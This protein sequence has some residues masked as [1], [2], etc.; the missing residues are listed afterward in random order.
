M[1]IVL[2]NGNTVEATPDHIVYVETENQGKI[3]KGTQQWLKV[4]QLEQGM[5]MLQRTDTLVYNERPSQDRVSEAILV[6]WLQGDGFVGQYESGTNRSLTLEFMTA[7]DE[8]YEFLL[9]H[10]ERIFPGI[11]YKVRGVETV[12][13]DLAL[14]RIRLYG[15]GLRN[16]VERYDLEK[17]GLEMRIPR[18]VLLGGFEV[19]TA[20]L[21]ALFQ[22]DGSV[23][24]HSG[25]TDSFDVVLGSIS[26]DLVRDAQKLLANLGIYS[27]IGVCDDSREDRNTY[28]QLILG[29]KGERR[30][31]Q[32]AIGFVSGEKSEKLA[33]SIDSDV[34]GKNIPA[35][36]FETVARIEYVGEQPV[37]DIQTES[38]NYLSGNVVVH[39][40][41]IQSVTDDLVNDNGIMDLWVREA[42]LFKFGSGTGTNFSHL[43][44]EGEPLSGG[45]R[46]SGLMSFLKVGDRAAGVIKS[47][48]T[49]RRAAKMVCLD[50]DHP[51]IESFI[52]WKAREEQK[53]SALVAG[54]KIHHEKLKAVLDACY[55]ERGQL[56]TDPTANSKL[57]DALIAAHEAHIPDGYLV[58]TLQL[59]QSG[60][61][62]IDFPTF[63]VDWQSEAYQ[64]VSGQNA[65]NSVR[66]PNLFFEKLTRGDNWQLRWRTDGRVC[67]EIA[68]AEIWDKIGYAAWASADPGI[69]CDTTIN[70][71]HTCPKDG[72][73]NASNPCSEYMFLDDTACNLASLNLL[74]FFDETTGEFRIEAFQHACRLWTV[75][76]EISV[77]MAQYPSKTIARRS[78]DYR[79]LG[80]GYANLGAL[81]MSMGVPYGSQKALAVTGALTAIMTG[82][83]YATSAE[84]AKEHGP[85]ARFQDNREE[86]LRVMRNHR[87]AAYHARTDEYEGLSILPMPIDEKD[88]PAPL[89]KAARLAWD[90]AIKAGEK[91]GFRNAQTTVI[92]PTGT[93]GLLMDCDTTGI[94]PDFALVKFKKLAGGGYFRIINQSVPRALSKLGYSPQEV[95]DIIAYCTGHG[96]LRQAPHI[97]NH[98]LKQLGFTDEVLKRLE[99]ELP[100]AFDLTFV[101]NPWTLGRDFC[102]SV[103]ELTNEEMADT[104]LNLLEKLGFSPEQ[105]E[106]AN[107]HICG[108]MT[109]EGAP[110]LKPEHYPVFD[111][112]GKCGRIGKRFLDYRTH[113]DMMAAAQPFISGAISK[114][115]NM[116]AEASIPEVQEAFS[117][118]W[119]KMVKAIAIY[120]DGSK[121]SQPLNA[122]VAQSIFAAM[123]K[124]RAGNMPAPSP[125]A[126]VRVVASELAHQAVRKEL[127]KRRFGYTVKAT[128]AGQRVYLRTGEYEDG[129]L[130]EIFIDVYKEGAAYRSLMN[131]FAIAVSLGM[132]YGVPLEEFVRKFHLF[133]FEP[134]GHVAD[135]D[136]IKFCSSIIDF[137]FRDLALNYLGRTDLVHVPPKDEEALAP[138]QATEALHVG[139][140]GGQTAAP[141]P[142][143]SMSADEGPTDVALTSE[144]WTNDRALASRLA[145]TRGYEGD[146]CTQCGQF[147][148]VRSGTCMRCVSCG[149]TSGCS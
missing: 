125:E 136:H 71:W 27:R 129:T 121:L 40:C 135:H 57:R 123:R 36:R 33:A 106:E 113:I 108:T 46:S 61:R 116:P 59:A 48:G 37:Y 56:S 9:P 14:R 139:H 148:L 34:R 103:L 35:K 87:R 5:R 72:R 97:N 69:Q 101:F 4:G 74:K 132:Q 98:S 96:S 23:R 38:G 83:A 88:C 52:E 140:G 50:L 2:K 24:C 78:F 28:F 138:A 32:E 102:R 118:A 49:T 145:R 85:F 82:E 117:S 29:Y 79:T 11:H 84:M 47:G 86:M 7:N 80:L 89:L 13:E 104:R 41:F 62:E 65:N 92:A 114:T 149:S 120:R 54:S 20:Y 133:R 105:I 44:G 10:I 18:S 68:A 77:L 26:A 124:A 134:N 53:V 126:E 100:M 8:E 66:V 111:C 115:I 64:T 81:L 110:H 45:G 21:R 42:R 122:T 146:P 43:R 1:R 39:N 16:F 76:L 141:A 73:I 60:G 107:Q 70:E 17:R 119:S 109:V 75:V 90:R 25:P 91:H 144:E 137:I 95:K 147:T 94:E 3:G 130:G 142:S 127:P 58:K 15:E 22:T 143:E 6:G 128:I 30:K 93:I 99:R 55:D 31:F 63:D 19:A 51:E 112:A 67:K 12:S 131:A